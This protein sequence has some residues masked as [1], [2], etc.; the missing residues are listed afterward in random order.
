MT[1]AGSIGHLVGIVVLA[2]QVSC[3]GG[4]APKSKSDG[5]R[6]WDIAIENLRGEVG[7]PYSAKLTWKDS[8]IREPEFEIGGLPPGLIFDPATRTISGTPEVAGFH[9]VDVAIRK[10]IPIDSDARPAPEDR[11]WTA[12]FQLEIYR[13]VVD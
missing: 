3:V 9:T 11:W 6:V 12:R 5:K 1:T 13:P 2:T 7:R 4:M 8:Y 10:R